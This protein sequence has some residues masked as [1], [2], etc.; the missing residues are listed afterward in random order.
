[1]VI[2]RIM[3]GHEISRKGIEMDKAKIDSIAK[4]PR[5]KCLKDIRYFL[6]HAGSIVGL[7]RTLL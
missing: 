3:L 1:M 6:G 2:Y 5:P 7:L 4:L